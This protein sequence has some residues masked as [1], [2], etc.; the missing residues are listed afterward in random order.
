[1]TRCDGP[2]WLAAAKRLTQAS[3]ARGASKVDGTGWACSSWRRNASTRSVRSCASSTSGV[4]A[5]DAR[6]AVSQSPPRST[7]SPS[8]SRFTCIFARSKQV[9]RPVRW[10][11]EPE[12]SSSTMRSTGSLTPG[13]CRSAPDEAIGRAIASASSAMARHRSSSTSRC[14]SRTRRRF[15]LFA[16]SSSSMAAQRTTL[17]RRL[18]SRWMMMGIEIAPSPHSSA[19][20]MKPTR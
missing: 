9:V 4:S 10:P 7:R 6:T 17:N 1:M 19:E 13:S 5:R 8:M 20:L 16:W 2:P 14:S 12:S 18:L 15:F 3:T 11:I